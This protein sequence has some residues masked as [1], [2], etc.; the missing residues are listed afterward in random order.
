MADVQ[1]AVGLGRKAG[2][3]AA[4]ELAAAVVLF[5]D[6]FDEVELPRGRGCVPV[7]RGRWCVR[8]PGFR[9]GV[10]VVVHAGI[11]QKCAAP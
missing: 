4:A 11:I 8:L 6:L 9:L 5:D 1:I 3:D 7:D 10:F 2:V